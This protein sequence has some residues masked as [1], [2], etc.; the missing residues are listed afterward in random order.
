MAVSLVDETRSR[1]VQ[2]AHR[3]FRLKTASV[4]QQVWCVA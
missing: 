4:V 3:H 2:A 1:F